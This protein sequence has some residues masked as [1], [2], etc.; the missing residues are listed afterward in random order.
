MPLNKRLN[1]PTFVEMIKSF[2]T[3]RHEWPLKSPLQKWC[4]FYGIGRA[5]FTLNRFSLYEESKELHWFTYYPFLYL[6]VHIALIFYTAYHYIIV[7]GEFAKFLP[8]TC[9][10]TIIA[11]VSF[12]LS[13]SL[14][15]IQ[16]N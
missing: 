5:F 13:L 1:I 9:M 11:T 7:R 16:I 4:Y 6:G 10:F 14:S 12:S 3:I 15:R 2:A 8:C